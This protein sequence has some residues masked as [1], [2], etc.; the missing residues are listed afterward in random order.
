M[1]DFIYN[2]FE[3]ALD[4]R[5]REFSKINQKKYSQKN[6]SII[7]MSIFIYLI[8]IKKFIE[9]PGHNAYMLNNYINLSC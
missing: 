8:N 7:M 9:F 1:P 4:T 6:R 5:N 3:K 2:Y